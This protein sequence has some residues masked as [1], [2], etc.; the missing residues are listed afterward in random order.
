MKWAHLCIYPQDQKMNITRTR[1]SPFGPPPSHCLQL[2]TIITPPPGPVERNTCL[3]DIYLHQ[4]VSPIF[5]LYINEIIPVFLGLA[6]F[7]F[8]SIMFLR[9]ILLLWVAA[10]HSPCCVISSL[11]KPYFIYAFYCWW[12]FSLSTVWGFYAAA[13]NIFVHAFYRI[14]WYMHF[15]IPAR[16]IAGL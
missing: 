7:M 11:T 8:F 14:S 3:P 13:R 2:L 15:C 9:F 6:S 16:G 4:L 10:I 5:K 1:E 12:T